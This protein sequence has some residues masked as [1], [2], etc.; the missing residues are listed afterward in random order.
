ME[1][2]TIIFD[3]LIATLSLWVVFKLTGHGGLVGESL[4]KIGY[5]TVIIGLSQIV[6]TTG[7]NL[8]KIDFSTIEIVHRFILTVGIFLIT[9]GFNNLMSKN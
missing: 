3:L 9:W 2:I 8:F 6:E 1:N 4:A 7:L 5:G